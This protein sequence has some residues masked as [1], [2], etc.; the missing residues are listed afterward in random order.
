AW[1]TLENAGI[2]PHTLRGTRTGVFTG[3]MYDDYGNRLMQASPDGFEGFLGTGSAS[4][5]A[6]GR[7]AYSFG[8]EGPAIS[9]DTAC[10]SSLVAL[11]LAVQALRN[12]ECDLALAGG[13]TVMA[14]PTAFIEFSRQRGLA[15]DGRSKSFSSDADGAAWSEGVGLL[16]V[17]RL[18][19]ARRNGHQVL[20]V[21]RGS[22]VNQDGASNGLTAPNGPAQI[23]LIREALAGAGLSAADVDAVEAHGTGTTLGDPIEAEA[24]LA[25]YGQNRERPLWLGSVKSNIGHTQSAA[26]AAGVIKMIQAIRHGMLPR[27]LHVDEP[28]PHVDWDSGNVRL[29]TEDRDWPATDRPRRAGISSFGISGTNAHIIIEEP[30]AVAE[31]PEPPRPAVVPWVV[32]GRNPQAVRA[33]AADLRA[34]LGRL[35]DDGLAAAGRALA[36]GRAELDHRAVVTG[37]DRAELTAALEAVASGSV[38]PQEVTEGK[39]AFLFTGQ[40]AQRPGMGAELH[41][42]FPVFAEAFDAALAELEQHVAVPLRD[43]LWG[44]DAEAVNR[45]EFAQA[46]LFAFNVALFR[47]V[48]SWGLRPDLLAG[49]SVGELAAAHVA[50]V[51]SLADAARLVAARGRLMQA[52]PDG[53][54]MAAVEATEDEVLPLL[55]PGTG[56][57]AVNGPRSVVVSGDGDAVTAIAAEF[58]SRGRR[59]SML[60]VSH[61]FHSLLMEPMVEEFRAVAESVAYASPAIPVVSTVSGE[62]TDAWSTA[63]Y[64]VRHVLATVRFADGVR[65]LRERGVTTFVELGPDAALSAAGPDSAPDAAFVPLL[66]RDQSEVAQLVAGLGRAHARGA[67]VDWAAFFGPRKWVDTPTYPFQHRHFWLHPTGRTGGGA[68]TGH[69][70]VTEVI[71]LPDDQGVIFTGQLSATTHPWLA[72]YALHGAAVV[73]ATV[74]LDIAL[75]AAHHVGLSGVERLAAETPLVLP[76]TG[77]ARLHVTVTPEEQGRRTVTVHCRPSAAPD[78]PWTRHAT[79]TIAD[80]VTASAAGVPAEWPP[81]GAVPLDPEELADRLLSIGHSG[82]DPLLGLRAAWRDGDV[83]HAELRATEEMEQNGF[84]LDPRLFQAALSA[85]GGG[86]DEPHVP[87]T[88]TGVTATT[89]TTASRDLRV[90]LAP[91]GTDTDTDTASVVVSDTTGAIVATVDAV[92]FR[93]VGPREFASAGLDLGYEQGWTAVSVSSPVDESRWAVLG[94]DTTGCPGVPGSPGSSGSSDTSDTSDTSGVHVPDLA[95]LGR[96]LD[97]G[98]PV[99]GAVLVPCPDGGDGDAEAQLTRMLE[100]THAWLSDERYADARLVVLTR[101]AV[102]VHDTDRIDNLGQA[103]VWGLLR[104][105]QAE[106]PD[107]FAVVDLDAE[108]TTTSVL[109]ALATAEPQLAVRDGVPYAPRLVR[110]TVPPGEA[111]RAARGAPTLDQ[112]G[113]VLVVHGPGAL[114]APLVRHLVREHGVRRLL[115]GRTPGATPPEAGELAELA[116]LGAEVTVAPGET[117]DRAGVADLLSR[118]SPEHPLTAV[119]HAVEESDDGV[120]T[121]LTPDR[122]TAVFRPRAELARHLH[123]LTA[124]AGLAAFVVF[125]SAAGTLGLRG[126]AHTA[127]AAAFLDALA[128]RRDLDGLPAVSLAWGPWNRPDEADAEASGAEAAHTARSGLRPTTVEHGLAAFDR[129]L[130]DGRARTMP[131]RLDH[132]ELRRQAR[133]GTLAPVFR[134]LI[135][136]P[137]GRAAGG[138]DLARRLRGLSEGEQTR[139]VREL[140]R[141]H[142]ASV[143]GHRSADSIDDERPLQELGFDSLTAVEL[144]NRLAS[145]LDLKLPATVLFDY[146]TASALAEHLRVQV[147]GIRRETSVAR[148]T[149]VDD[150]PIAIVGMACRYP[151]G[152]VSPDALWRLVTEGTDAIGEFPTDRGWDLDALYDPDPERRGTTYTRSGGF[153]PELGGFDAEFFGIS[154]RE[155]LA[156]DPQQRLLLETSWET[157]ENA[158]IGPESLRGSRTGVFT[159]TNGQDY[160]TLMY[161]NNDLDGYLITGNAAS[162]VSGR[163]SYTFGLE[164][165]AISVDTACSSSLVALHLAAQALRN[166]ECD[167]ALAGGVSVMS[168]PVSFIDFSRQRG[169][170]PDGRSKSFAAAADGTGWGEGVGLLLV[171]RVSDARRNGHR[172]LAVVRGSAVNQ[173]GQSSQLSAPN[174]PAQQ[175]VIRQAL[176]SAGL[177]PADVD[178]VEAHGTGTTLGDPIEAQALIATYGQDR[179]APLWLGSIKSNI[180]H[181]AAAAGVAGIIKMVQ[182][183]RHGLLPKTLHV[184]EPTPH[185]DWDSGNVQLLTE[186]RD[187]PATDRPRR[188]GIS[189]FGIS[190]TNA[191]IIIEQAPDQDPVTHEPHRGPVAW[192]LSAKTEPALRDQAAHLLHHIETHPHLEPA[193]VARTLAA[194]TMFTHRASIVGT[195]LDDFRPALT[196]LKDGTPAPNLTQGTATPGKTVF[197]FPGQGSQWTGMGLELLTTSPVFAHHIHACDEALRPHTGWSLLSVLR[198]EPDTPDPHRVDVLQPTLFALM[199]A[200][201]RTWQHH[202]TTPDAVIGHSQGEI[203]AAHIAGTLTLND[204]AKTIALRSQAIHHLPH[205]GTM[206]HIPLPAHH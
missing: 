122:V 173:D 79:G 140:V 131:V 137:A 161:G 83:V 165:P 84:V 155:A 139:V 48:E 57:A 4:S 184:D 94:D 24:I 112:D 143:L 186:T 30:S 10:S 42:V 13:V 181:S 7:I 91:T 1:E 38:A 3:V 50:G 82:E 138:H 20:A 190:G 87:A 59:T 39:V 167:L 200:L 115:L 171:E 199:I 27:T 180:G 16:L 95:A 113:T 14:T 145:S 152:A 78:A 15:P 185:V 116:A 176:A 204:A 110:P 70:V 67:A 58:T 168:T 159:G 154:P 206:A 136:T 55:T 53:G 108:A 166:G 65:T 160:L 148:T 102:A 107:R 201:A 133:A 63:E 11:H 40:G 45:T 189:S 5:V 196:A 8:L 46:G 183:I 147:L 25:T 163:L 128:H 202:G 74:L 9:V 105:A 126:Q 49:H 192:L 66:R 56:L 144:R 17:E 149:G 179:E 125:S 188:A 47:L 101:G 18:S 187:W 195:S 28:T 150:E 54:A 35:P 100:L 43:V 130:T 109:A 77:A 32:S 162:I 156:M 19:D 175:R 151:G 205:T 174:G 22:A 80:D 12:G 182:A 68:T 76:E 142:I 41:A 29:L 98:T 36:T 203:A 172:I 90:R 119:V 178:A 69:P 71:E 124:D 93:P 141:T 61:A 134:A 31:T 64:W 62:A 37:A 99:P 164:G 92:G 2:N 127:A 103:A 135:R 97:E 170:A 75:H 114:A 146:P 89:A 193:A 88:W 153:L 96:L 26:G 158:G 117:T 132:S 123:E 34:F 73:P 118:V 121:A 169:L 104:S 197:V 85:A 6:S 60:R 81:A 23:Q 21:V 129:A 86:G 52:L 157:F 33:R 194:R 106:H 177:T 111:A 51:L 44:D 72:A 198:G 191:H 120:L